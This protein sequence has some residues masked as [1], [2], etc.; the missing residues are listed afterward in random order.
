MTLSPLAGRLIA[1]GVLANLCWVVCAFGAAPLLRQMAGDRETIASSNELLARY[2]RLEASLPAVQAQLDQL[3]GMS[4]TAKYFFASASPAL[5]AAEMQN[6]L[7]GLVT[8]SGALLRNSKSLQAAVEKGFDRI[9]LDVDLTA[10]AA[11]LSKL[12]RALAGAEPIVVVERL[13]AQVP[14]TGATSTAADGQPALSVNLRLV[15]YA[16]RRQDSAK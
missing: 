15:S 12:L 1:W 11:E 6:S 16:R 5:A 14:E 4:D 7:R 2:R 13:F 9:G 10:S 3:Q 8:G